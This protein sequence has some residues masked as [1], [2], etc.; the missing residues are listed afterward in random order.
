MVTN[1][2][3]SGNSSTGGG[4]DGGGGGIS[5][6]GPLTVTNSTFS[7]NSAPYGGAIEQ[8]SANGE[9]C[10]NCPGGLTPAKSHEND[11]GHAQ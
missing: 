11:S 10:V 5:S 9:L 4:V 2:T 3:F 1:S 7:G 8:F 6:N